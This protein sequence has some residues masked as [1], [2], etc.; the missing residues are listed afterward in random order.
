[1]P[2]SGHLTGQAQVRCSHLAVG[3]RDRKEGGPDPL[4][5][6]KQRYPTCLLPSTKEEL[7]ENRIRQT[8][9]TNTNK[10]LP[11]C[12]IVLVQ[13]MPMLVINVRSTVSPCGEQDGP[14]QPRVGMEHSWLLDNSGTET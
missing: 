7:P 2:G 1:M 11:C 3:A 4:L 5:P 8:N 9:Q 13:H 12:F 10:Y 6:V 14:W